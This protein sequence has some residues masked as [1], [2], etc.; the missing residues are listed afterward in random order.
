MPD[1]VISE[2]NIVLGIKKVFDNNNGVKEHPTLHVY[3]PKNRAPK[4]TKQNL[5]ASH[6]KQTNP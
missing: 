2:Q 4:Y 6:R 3:V 5:I 1:I